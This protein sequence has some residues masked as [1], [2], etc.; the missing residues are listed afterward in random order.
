MDFYARCAGTEFCGLV[1]DENAN[2]ENMAIADAFYWCYKKLQFDD[3]S[4]VESIT[5]NDSNPTENV[6]KTGNWSKALTRFYSEVHNTLKNEPCY[7]T[8]RDEY[9]KLFPGQPKKTYLYNIPKTEDDLKKSL[10]EF[11]NDPQI[12]EVQAHLQ[13][14]WNQQL[15]PSALALKK[16][17]T[18]PGKLEEYQKIYDDSIHESIPLIENV[19]P[20]SVVFNESFGRKFGNFSKTL[21]QKRNEKV[22]AN[23]DLYSLIKNPR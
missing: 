10:T 3:N 9:K 6:K 21:V 13:I 11:A 12:K 22:M 20:D 15:R 14:Y 5:G 7:T 2:R 18:M 17:A 19:L 23:A 1:E 4:F 16:L 8:R